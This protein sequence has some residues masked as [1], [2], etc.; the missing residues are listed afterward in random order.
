MRK[1]DVKIMLDTFSI[2]SEESKR[3]IKHDFLRNEKSLSIKMKFILFRINESLKTRKVYIT[4]N[5][6]WFYLQLFCA[7]KYDL[8][9]DNPNFAKSLS[10]F[11]QS[12]SETKLEI[13][14]Q[15]KN[16][17]NHFSQKYII[18]E[19]TY[20]VNKSSPINLLNLIYDISNWDYDET[21]QKWI[22]DYFKE[23]NNKNE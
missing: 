9:E 14:I 18:G 1:N 23:E 19:V 7:N 4:E 5:T 11:G 15:Q 16:Y 22:Q 21:K 2:I 13:L 12:S 20:I 10:A 3:Q 8:G 6:L 17:N